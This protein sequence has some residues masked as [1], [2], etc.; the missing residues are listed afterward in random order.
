M[1]VYAIAL[2]SNRPHGR[3]GRP[4]AVV[5]AAAASLGEDI[6][7]LALSPIF[8]T[9]AVGDRG[10][11]FANAAATIETELDPPALLARLKRIERA[12]GRR[13]GKRWGTRVLDL[14]ILLWSGGRWRSPRPRLVV[15]HPALGQ[16]R[17]V[18]DPLIHVAR[19]WP[20][21]GTALTV[22]HARACL[23]A[24]RPRD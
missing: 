20:L 13:R 19:D 17:F 11:R 21:A 3:F 6:T 5:R 4:E 18:L 2:G 10:R 14:D 15:P 9:Q 12:F 1:H 22:A 8:A 16:R 7:L 23:M 24:A